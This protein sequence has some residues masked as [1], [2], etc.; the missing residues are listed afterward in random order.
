MTR[1][2]FKRHGPSGENFKEC[3]EDLG[4]EVTLIEGLEQSPPMV[5]TAD[6]ALVYAPQKAII[7]R[8]DGPR[9]FFGPSAVSTWFRQRGF[10]VEALP[11]QYNL[12]GGNILKFSS[13]LYCIGVKPGSS[14]SSE[15]YLAKLL[16]FVYGAK[17]RPLMLCDRRFLHLDMVV[18]NLGGR[19]VLVY[20]EGLHPVSRQ[21][22][23]R[24]WFKVPLIAVSEEDAVHFACNCITVGETVIT[25][26]ISDHLAAEI[27]SFGFN[28][29]RLDLSEFYKPAEARSV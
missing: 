9:S 23:R 6:L 3:L 2:I 15:R 21:H 28:V 24:E 17:A 8:N 29:V 27:A 7:L 25:G 20:W 16:N 5:F 13:A 11:P 10:N 12:D 19:A 4:A 18:G 1:S 14:G 26:P 22:L